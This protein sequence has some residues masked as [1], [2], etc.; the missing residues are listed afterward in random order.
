MTNP[1]SNAELATLRKLA[2]D[3]AVARKE[4]ASSLHVLAAIAADAGPAGELLRDRR[5]DQDGLLKV[6]RGFE[7]EGEGALTRA[8]TAAREMAQ[9]GSGAE[10][11]T[12]H[13]LL[14]L[15]ADRGLAAHRALAQAGVDLGRLRAAAM[16]VAL[17]VVAA[18][19]PVGMSSRRLST[20]PALPTS[21]ASRLHGTARPRQ[22]DGGAPEARSALPAQ[23]ARKSTPPAGS[24]GSSSQAQPGVTV[25]LLPPAPAQRRPPVRA[26][27]KGEPVATTPAAPPLVSSAPPPR[28][29]APAEG[30]TGAQAVQTMPSGSFPSLAG[31][32]RR[33]APAR[34]AGIGEALSRFAL[35]RAKFPV[36]AAVG[37]NLTLAAAEGSLEP[38]VGREAEIDH[39]LDVLAKRHANSPCLVGPAGVGKTAVA[40]GIAHRLAAMQDDPPHGGRVLVELAVSELVAGAGGR[41]ALA[42][43]MAAVRTE[44]REAAGRVILFI[45]DLHELFE[46]HAFAEAAAEI[47]IALGRGELA[48]VGATRPEE[49][50]RT[51]ES[52]SALARRFTMIEVEEPAE[53]EAFLLLQSVARSLGEHH[54]LEYTDE[55]LAASVAWSM[56]YLPG[57]ALPDKAIAVL[58]LAGARARRR[59]APGAKDDRGVVAASPEGSSPSPP[60][61]KARRVGPREVAEVVSELVDLPVER[62]LETDRERMLGLEKILAERV[63]GHGAALARIAKVLRRNAAGLRSRRPIGTFLLLGPTGVGKTETAKAIAEALF[64]SPDAMTRLDFSEYAEAHA[65]ARLVGAP[66]GYV[67][68]EAGGQLTEAVRRRPYQVILLDELEKAHRD[69]LEAFLQVFDEGR[70]TDGRGRRVDFTN[71]VVVMTSNLGAAEV[72]AL[73]SA[74]SV[75]FAR[76]SPSASPTGDAVIAAAR[77]ALPPELYNRID[78]VLSYEPLTREDVAEIARRLLDALAASLGQ[79]GIRMQVEPA[80]IDVLLASGGFD[81]SLGARPMKRAIGRL[82]EAPLAEMILRREVDDGGVALVGVEDGE[83]AI[84]ALSALPAKSAAGAA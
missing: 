39:A 72:A 31:L 44:A 4:R 55:A 48:L 70:M 3:L 43:R 52:D 18:R 80:V 67:G 81:G 33:V 61:S 59:R 11:S 45:D 1:R 75:G 14:A 53:E 57:R 5:L 10:V 2:H 66:P 58:D 26:P 35:D 30:E 50:R 63:V 7:D 20:E 84:D 19:R 46:T 27:G 65:I 41:A 68:H 21:S 71:T 23:D 56:R 32:G 42:E 78:E 76:S 64:H 74:R 13:V 29:E 25:R 83:I 49:L 73:R 79:R 36:L 17:G 69:V 28:V 51:I 54:R 77:A 15:L 9:R 6:G 47:K 12:L 82:I 16:Q 8:M 24:Q 62:L 37:R 38:I 22:G 34:K 40:R 60:P